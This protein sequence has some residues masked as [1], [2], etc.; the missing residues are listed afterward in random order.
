MPPGGAAFRGGPRL[1]RLGTAAALAALCACVFLQAYSSLRI[2]SLTFDEL[3]YIPAGYSYVR[4][5]DYRL[6]KEQPP[7]MKLLAGAALLPLVPRLPTEHWSWT[8]AA[9]G[10]VG[11]TQWAFGRE[12]LIGANENGEALVRAAR[13]PTVLLTMLLVVVA[14][15]F[16]RDLY[17]RPAGLLAAVLCAFSPN[18]LA[19]GRLATTDLGLA[20]FVLLSVYAYRRFTR[21]PTVPKLLF[22]GTALGLALVTKFSAVLLLPLTGLWAVALPLMSG[23]VPVPEGPWARLVEPPKLRA[24]A[25]SLG[26]AAA[27][28]LVALL[29]TSL[30]YQAPGRIDI[31]FRDLGMVG[32]NTQPAYLT[33]FNGIFHERRVPYYFVAAF[34]LK[35]PLGFLLLLAARAALSLKRSEESPGD[36]L[37]LFAPIALWVG[38]VSWR[39]FQLGLRYILPVYPLLFVYAAGIVATPS[40]GRRG[41]RLAV[42]GLAAWFMASSLRAHP[43]YLP[44]F[45]ELAGGPENGIHWLDDSNVDWGQDLILLRDFIDATGEQNLKV[46]PM[47]QY[48]PI[49]YGIEAEVV[50]ARAVVRLLSR[51]NPPP[52]VYAVSAHVLNRARLDRS[53]PVDPLLDLDPV[54]VLGHSM[55]VFAFR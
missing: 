16:A 54:V 48:D 52:G 1:R 33:Y 22:A 40:F 8:D 10:E 24:L 23:G 20:C 35:T 6:N 25:F 39:A 9:D 15:L 36:R 2:K 17:G 26:S 34:L 12:F 29:V 42:A 31:Y 28:G 4:T 14:Y 11:N 47:A 18:L 41:V 45:N 53:A 43:H 44:Y 19:H 30:A 5:G 27:I 13:L 32:V 50:P 3:A 46:T 21:A 49:L 38:V 7:L 51:P 37:L 55:Y